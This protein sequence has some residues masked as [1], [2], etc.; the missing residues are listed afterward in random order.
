MRIHKDNEIRSVD[1]WFRWAPPKRGALHWKDNRSAKELAKC[2]FRTGTAQA[3]LELRT[4]LNRTFDAE[5]FFEEAVPECTVELDDFEGETRNCDLVV[6]CQAG[7][8]RI[9]ISVEAKADEPFG[10]STAGEYYDKKQGSGSNVPKRIEQLSN[11]LFGRV[12][13]EQIRGLRYQLVHSAAAS[14]IAAQRHHAEIAVLLVHEFISPGLS[15]RKLKQNSGDW[16]AFVRVFPQLA[17][18]EVCRDKLLGP[19]SVPSGKYVPALPLYLGKLV[20]QLCPAEE[21]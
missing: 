12:P 21:A 16:E 17:D 7:L 20:T 19:V 14:L 18:A 15:L 3:P 1:D 8:Q 9:V 13:D 2:W 5:I 10:E 6:V 11:A 4:L